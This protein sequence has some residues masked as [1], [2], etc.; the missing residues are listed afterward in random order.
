MFLVDIN[1]KNKIHVIS[2]PDV[3]LILHFYIRLHHTVTK[4]SLKSEFSL[5]RKLDLFVWI[6]ALYK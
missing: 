1:E 4:A 5:S 3:N 6:K 2:I